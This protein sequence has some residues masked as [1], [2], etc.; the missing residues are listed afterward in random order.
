MM[1]SL[2][3]PILC[4]FLS[5][6]ISANL[7]SSENSDLQIELE[8]LRKEKQILQQELAN[9]AARA[10]A[11]EKRLVA[12]EAARNQPP[13]P[14]ADSSGPS[15]AQKPSSPWE[16]EFSLGANLSSGN[17][18]S[19]RLNAAL[20]GVRTTELDKLS[21]G[22]QGEVGQNEGQT[23]AQRLEGVADYQRDVDPIWYWYVNG[24]AEHD[25]IAGLDYRTTLG[26]GLGWHVI[27]T[28]TVILDLEGGPAW[29]AEQLAGNRLEHSLRGRIAQH[30]EWQFTRS[31]KIYQDLEF[32][33]NLQDIED[34]LLIAEIGVETNLTET[35]SLRV[36]AEDRYDNQPAA[37]RQRND[38]FLKSS[39]VY[40]FK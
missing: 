7:Q 32:L 25:D 6:L 34:W 8:Q 9:T 27:R 20:K 17:N 37:G 10:E 29:V 36:S 4:L 21:L 19:S 24:K 22:L 15:P 13:A 30:F 26:P 16:A 1:K 14:T 35:L 31:A 38:L 2:H 40:Q 23:N 18:D 39:I 5:A 28:D 11:L 33:D 12:M 3:T